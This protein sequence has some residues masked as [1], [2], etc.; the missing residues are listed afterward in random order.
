MIV[1]SHLCSQQTYVWLIVQTLS[2]MVWLLDCER[3]DLPAPLA[4]NNDN[5][6]ENKLSILSLNT[7][8]KTFGKT[9]YSCLCSLCILP[10]TLWSR[11]LKIRCTCGCANVINKPV[12]ARPKLATQIPD[13][14]VIPKALPSSPVVMGHCKLGLP[15]SISWSNTPFYFSFRKKVI[16]SRDTRSKMGRPVGKIG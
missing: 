11:L 14:T 9:T 4:G 2:S 16:H 3:F 15:T 6:V 10:S 13:S 12:M 1:A 7:Q 5:W 8:G